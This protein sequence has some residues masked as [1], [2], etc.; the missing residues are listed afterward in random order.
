MEFK[1]HQPM[2]KYCSLRAGGVADSLFSPNTLKE[3]TDF[4]R[5]NNKP[6]LA[7]GLGSNLL[8]RDRGFEGVVIRLNRLNLLQ[9]TT[10]GINA[11]AGVTLAKLSRFCEQKGFFGAEFLSAIPGSLGGALAMNAGAFGSEIWDFVQSVETIDQSGEIQKRNKSDFDVSYREVVAHHADEF[12][13]SAQLKFNQKKQ[14]QTIK[15]LLK[16]RNATQPTGSANCGSVF[17]NPKGLYAAELIEKSNLKG[18]CIGG[19][20]VSKKHANYIINQN[21]ASAQEIENL[22]QHIQSVVKSNFNIDL[23]TELRIV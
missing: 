19:A 20:C 11:Q 6:I 1:H 18:Y 13:L 21:N 2:S 23:E 12:F 3:L 14:T 7:L 8:V 22:I 17:K 15:A 16:K 9:K 4:L 5:N 10:G